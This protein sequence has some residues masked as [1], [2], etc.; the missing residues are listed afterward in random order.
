VSSGKQFQ[1]TTSG[2]LDCTTFP[3]LFLA[4]FLLR[5]IAQQNHTKT[6]KLQTPNPQTTARIHQY[7][8]LRHKNPKTI[9][10]DNTNLQNTITPPP[11]KNPS[12]QPKLT[13]QNK[14]TN[15]P[16]TPQHKATQ[17]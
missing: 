14:K 17:P 15:R 12:L 13:N 10:K 3:L 16:E 1:S 9:G 6:F 8:G 2:E 11:P 4:T 7:N 5:F